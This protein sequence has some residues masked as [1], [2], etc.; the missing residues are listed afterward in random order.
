[1]QR[2][3]RNGAEFATAIERRITTLGRTK[4]GVAAKVATVLRMTHP[5]ALKRIDRLLVE[6]R[7][8]DLDFAC[9]L[10]K[11]LGLKIELRE[12]WS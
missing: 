12:I 8:P 11:E 9:A 3:I 4:Y 1:M 6:G 7:V 2:T 5:A 10:A